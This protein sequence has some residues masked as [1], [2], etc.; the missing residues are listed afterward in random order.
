MKNLLITALAIVAVFGVAQSS[1]AQAAGPKGGAGKQGAGA[2]QPGKG[3]Q[4]GRAWMQDTIK[5]LNLDA[6]QEKKMKA[7]MKSQQEKMKDLREKSGGDRTKMREGFM[8]LR[9]GQEAEMKKILTKE[10]W[11]KYEKAREEAMKKMRAGGGGKKGGG[12]TIPPVF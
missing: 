11:A 9:K 7:L 2:A 12:K 3:Q 1:F 10:Q 6:D 4:A 5:S 8:E